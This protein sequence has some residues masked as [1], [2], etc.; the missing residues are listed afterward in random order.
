M[1][2]VTGGAG[3]IGSAM[4]WKLNAMGI[5]DILVVDTLE[6]GQKWKNIRG[7]RFDDIYMPDEFLDMVME[8]GELP[9]DTEAVIHMGA[10]SRTTEKDADYLLRN[11]YR[12]TK[13]LAQHAVDQGIRFI[14]ASSAATYGNGELG[15]D[16]DPAL[17]ERLL[18]LNMYGHSKLMVDQWLYHE[19]Y[20]DAVASLRFFN[21]YGPNEYHKDDMASMVYKAFNTVQAGG[22][23]GLFKSYRPEYKDGE[24]QRDF[25]YIKDVVDCLW[26]LVEHPK[27]NGILNIGTGSEATWNELAGALFAALGKEPA[28]DYVEMPEA[29]R[30][31]YQY[32][33]KADITR[34][35]NAGYTGTFRPVADGVRDYVQNHLLLDNPYINNGR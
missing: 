4:V 35:R 30:G 23:L 2:I 22:R 17:L 1:F 11:N 6:T 9:H 16:D 13:V 10:C 20:I 19:G 18:P 29:I 12:Y 14:N 26:W 28:I 3:F 31:Q 5:H 15:Y 34:L 24:Q 32:H 33:T 7:L 27:V 25:V 21:V 8:M